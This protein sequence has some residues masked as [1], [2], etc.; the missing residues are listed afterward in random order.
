MRIL[1]KV[2]FKSQFKYCLLSWMFYSRSTNNRIN[3]LAEI[4]LRLVYHDYELTFDELLEKDGS[5]IIHHYNIQTL[6]TEL[7][8][9]YHNLSQSIF[10]E[11]FTQNNSTYNLWS[12][13][14]FVIPQMSILFK[15]SSSISFY[16]PIIFSLVPEKIRYADS[17]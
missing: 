8:K 1:F 4:A 3:H 2:F 10:S 9:V 12:K 14:D 13:S 5:F 6:C 17:L 15:G 7:Y 11:L 16:G